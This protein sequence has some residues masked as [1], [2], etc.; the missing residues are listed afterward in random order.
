L[1]LQ[2]KLALYNAISKAIIILAIGAIMPVVIK[3]VV[4]NHIDKRL[5]ARLEKTL[6]MVQI[7]GINE[8]TLD[9]DCSYGNYNIF[10]EE[11]VS[12]SPLNAL[13]SDFG[14]T[15]IENTER[16]IENDIVQHRV[17]SKAFIYDN[18]LYKIE[19]GEGLGAVEQLKLTI[20]RFMLW[21]MTIVI[22]LTIFLDLGFARILLRPFNKIINVKLK[23]VTHPT[24][25]DGTRIRSSTFEFSLLDRSIND[26]M[27]K[28]KEAF[29]IEREFI[30]NVSHELLT[31]ISILQTRIENIL[32]DPQLPDET[33]LRLVDSQRTLTRLT[34]IVRALLYI[35]KIENEQFLRNE[36]ASLKGLVE[37]I[38]GEMDERLTEKS[39]EV[40]QEWEEDF[41]CIP[42]NRSLLFTLLFNLISNSIKYNKQNGKIT[43]HGCKKSDGYELMIADTGQGIKEEHIPHIFDR[44]KRF[45]PEDDMSYGLGLPIVRTIAQFHGIQIQVKSHPGDGSEFRLLFP[46]N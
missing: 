15:E 24:K 40:K 27:S 8:I 2:S 5:N 34:R 26:M 11:F 25:F 43:I 13:P 16:I 10:K 18:Q 46:N 31:P 37:E 3:Q 36:S 14:K 33:A 23:D 39:I 32:N 7:G 22:L 42:C 29:E 41:I 4:Y 45:R 35:S 44:F 1:K 17:L 28:I 19:I 30:T 20:R 6:R 38:V 9:E 21:M 12:I